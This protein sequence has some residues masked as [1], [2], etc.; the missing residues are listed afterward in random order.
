MGIAGGRNRPIPRSSSYVLG[1]FRESR[2]EVADLVGRAADEAERLVER[3][4]SE[5]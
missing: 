1:R 4:R 5:A 2:A 3:L